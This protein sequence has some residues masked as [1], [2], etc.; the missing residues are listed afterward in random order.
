MQGWSTNSLVLFGTFFF[1]SPGVAWFANIHWRT[2]TRITL[3]R[4]YRTVQREENSPEG[5]ERRTVQRENSRRQRQKATRAKGKAHPKKSKFAP[6]ITRRG[7]KYPKTSSN[8][9]DNL[10]AF[11]FSS[12]CLSCLMPGPGT[13]NIQYI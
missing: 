8:N 10:I 9:S 13:H 4:T 3:C 11:Y 5:G 7:E 6:D 1:L 12:F 2:R